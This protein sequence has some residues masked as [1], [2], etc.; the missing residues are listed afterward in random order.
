[1]KALCQYTSNPV[2]LGHILKQACSAP[3]AKV[4]PVQGSLIR[5]P[6]GVK[7]VGDVVELLVFAP[8]HNI[9]ILVTNNN[10][11][12][13]LD[14]QLVEYDHNLRQASFYAQLLQLCEDKHKTSGN[15]FTIDFSVPGCTVEVSGVEKGTELEYTLRAPR[16]DLLATPDQMPHELIATCEKI[17]SFS[18]KTSTPACDRSVTVSKGQLEIMREISHYCG[19]SLIITKTD[20]NGVNYEFAVTNHGCCIALPAQDSY[21]AKVKRIAF[22]RATIDVTGGIYATNVSF[23]RLQKS[24]TFFEAMTRG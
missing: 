21:P 23:D 2:R 14:K 11:L 19:K 20:G 1:M 10:A 16:G 5:D 8:V 7:V 24:P 22:T 17:K 9:P 6:D 15:P 18:Y 12:A 13:S 4:H 3:L